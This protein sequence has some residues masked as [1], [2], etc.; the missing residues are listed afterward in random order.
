[1]AKTISV[2]KTPK[3][4]YQP[5]R[6]VSGLLDAQ[7]QNVRQVIYRKFGEKWWRAQGPR[8]P[9]EKMTAAFGMFA[10]GDAIDYEVVNKTPQ[11][12]DVD[13]VGCRYAKFYK[14]LGEPELGFLLLCSADFPMAEGFGADVQLHRTQTIMQGAPCCDFRYSTPGTEVAREPSEGTA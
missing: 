1:M 2:G 8:N 6:K 9:E 13:V 14:E 11:A 5:E 3:S 4:A 10:A 7:V 12:F